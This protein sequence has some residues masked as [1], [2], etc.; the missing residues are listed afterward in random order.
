M[1]PAPGPA[2]GPALGHG[3]IH[4]SEKL[5]GGAAGRGE[6]PWMKHFGALS[7]LP[8]EEHEA[9]DRRIEDFCEQIDEEKWS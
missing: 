4:H 9:I 7:D 3:V 1:R 6:K 2:L 8:A 5:A